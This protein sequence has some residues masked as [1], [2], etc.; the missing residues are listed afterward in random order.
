MR[1]IDNAGQPVGPTISPPQPPVADIL[2]GR[3]V[4]RGREK[5]CFEHYAAIGN[6]EAA[7]EA[8]KAANNSSQDI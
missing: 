4:V 5:Q 7:I 2:K 8:K 1:R 6:R 3:R